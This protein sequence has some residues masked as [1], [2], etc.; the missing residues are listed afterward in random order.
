MLGTDQEI[1]SVIQIHTESIILGRRPKRAVCTFEFKYL[2]DNYFFLPLALDPT[3]VE[4][5][6]H[7]WGD[8]KLIMS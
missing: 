5:H 1:S 4:I 2:S 8:I 6:S 7:D 3:I